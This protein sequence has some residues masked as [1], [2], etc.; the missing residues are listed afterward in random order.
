MTLVL[1]RPKSF[2]GISTLLSRCVGFQSGLL[3]RW[4]SELHSKPSRK[5]PMRDGQEYTR[6]TLIAGIAG[7]AAAPALAKLGN[8]ATEGFAQV[9]G[10]RVWWLRVGTGSRTPLLLLHGGPGAAHDYLLP[11]A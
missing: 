8:T 10:G 3:A 6:R 1:E 7:W 11:L 4:R 5:R 9:P 2:A